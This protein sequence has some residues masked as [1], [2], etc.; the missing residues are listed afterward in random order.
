MAE[1]FNLYLDDSGTR[2]PDKKT[3]RKPAHGYDWFGMGGILIDQFDEKAEK[4]RHNDFCKKWNIDFPLRSADIRAKS[5]EFTF[6]GRLSEEKSEEFYEEL[7]QLMAQMPVIGFASVIDR[8]GYK[9]R[10]DV[11]GDKKWLLCK[12]AFSTVVE[13]AAKY[14]RSK[15]MKLRV[16]VEE[17]DKK[18]DNRIR[19][20]YTSLKDEG[21]PFNADTS[22]KYKPLADSEFSET[23]YE[24]RLKRKTSKIMQIADLYLWP[25]CIGGYDQ[26]NRPYTRLID[27][28]KLIDCYI[29]S[30]ERKFLGIKYSC[31]ELV[32]KNI[33]AR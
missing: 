16:L 33:K 24:L 9:T 25:M 6:I 3:G 8:P 2:H 30:E 15:D 20:Y 12:T 23:L 5:N 11:Y 31:W 13:R 7:Y 4:K 21:M 14:A 29:K 19:E 10:Y 1:V 27:D 22:A 26:G 28:K 18:T 17:S 32:S